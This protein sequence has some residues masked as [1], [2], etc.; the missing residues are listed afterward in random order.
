MMTFLNPLDALIPKIQFSFFLLNL[1]PGHL[2][3]PGV[4]LGRIL[5]AC[6]LSP[7]GVGSSQRAVST[8]PPPLTMAS[9][10]NPPPSPS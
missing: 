9:C 8:P 7:F 5:G 3:G 4:S 6:Q 2:R 1:G 10:Q